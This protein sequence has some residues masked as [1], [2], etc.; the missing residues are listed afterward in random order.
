MNSHTQNPNRERYEMTKLCN[1][2]VIF[3]FVSFAYLETSAFSSNGLPSTKRVVNTPLFG[4]SEKKGFFS[5]LLEEMD[6]FVDD[7]TSRRLGA[8]SA[9]YGKRKSSFYGDEDKNKKKDNAQADPTED[10]QGPSQSG[11]FKWMVRE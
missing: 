8:G 6:A 10:Y 2:A 11:Y 1:A 7:A 9:F 3:A 4:S 5:N